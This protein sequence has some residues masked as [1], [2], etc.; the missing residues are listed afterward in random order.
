MEFLEMNIA[1]YGG[2]AILAYLVGL[3]ASAVPVEN[4]WI[5]CIV[6]AFGLLMGILGFY[7]VPDFPAHNLIDAAAV[8]VMSGLFSTGVDQIR[9]QLHPSDKGRIT[10]PANEGEADE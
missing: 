1:S 9:K 5:P 7:I 8:G 4:K 10:F 2:I 6:G 3:I